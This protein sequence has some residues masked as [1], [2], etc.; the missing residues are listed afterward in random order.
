MDEGMRLLI[1]G[2]YLVV[3]ASSGFNAWY[4][5]AFRSAGERHRLG[6]A[7]MAVVCVGTFLESLYVGL[8]WAAGGVPWS[9]EVWWGIGWWLVARGFV[10]LGSL[11]IS[12]L[13]LRRL[14]G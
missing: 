12:L 7:V 10:S 1:L 13:I 6:A 11:L 3:T 8:F 9:E 2:H 14:W 5:G 4:F